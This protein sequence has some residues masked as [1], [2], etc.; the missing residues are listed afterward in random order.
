MVPQ[1]TPSPRYPVVRQ[2]KLTELQSHLSRNV[3][4]VL[5]DLFDTLLILENEHESYVHSLEKMHSYLAGVGLGWTFSDFLEAYFGVV[6]KIS[7]ETASSLEEPHFR[8]YVSRTLLLMGD[9]FAGNEEVVCGAIEAFCSE[10]KRYVRMDPQAICVLE[11]L[12][13]NYKTGLISNLTFSE[14]AKELLE[15]S[16]LADFFDTIVI[17]GDVNMRKPHPD[18]F[19]LALNDLG[20]D[21]SE[22]V[23]VGDNLETD[24]LGSK[25]AGMIAVHIKRKTS[26]PSN[27]EPF[28][29]IT[30]LKQLLPLVNE[31]VD[32]KPDDEQ[33]VLKIGDAN[34]VYGF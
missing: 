6:E 26:K 1:R 10:F 33:P 30:D 22:A 11:S 29:T 7:R 5:F 4:A 24:V 19:N 27:V 34:V 16:K 9:E 32:G 8:E 2:M 31:R 15:E 12:S 20:V 21:P 28:R 13:A 25:N 17:S 3:K 23:F 14:C 18:I